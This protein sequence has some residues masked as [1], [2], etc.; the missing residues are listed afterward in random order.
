MADYANCPTCHG[1]GLIP[2]ADAEAIAAHTEANADL[3]QMSR[4]QLEQEALQLRLRG[5]TAAAEKR[6]AEVEAAIH[7]I[8]GPVAL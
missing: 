4:R 3:A 7:G 5:R 1:R 8:Y 2:L 6:L